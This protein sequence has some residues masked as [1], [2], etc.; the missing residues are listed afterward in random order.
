MSLS[1]TNF[2]KLI[3]VS[4]VFIFGEL[5]MDA[6]CLVSQY[7]FS[8]K[9]DV[10]GLHATMGLPPFQSLNRM[11]AEHDRMLYKVLRIDARSSYMEKPA[12]VAS[13]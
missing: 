11:P 1:N 2:L 13:L 6:A 12:E 5:R 9:Q 4:I 8:G 3:C 10:P 7:N